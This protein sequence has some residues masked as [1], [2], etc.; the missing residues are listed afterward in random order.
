MLTPWIY[1]LPLQAQSSCKAVLAHGPVAAWETEQPQATTIHST[2]HALP[3]QKSKGFILGAPQPIVAAGQL[4][5]TPMQTCCIRL[6]LPAPL[7]PEL[8]PCLAA[9]CTTCFF[10][11]LNCWHK[12]LFGQP[13]GAARKR[14]ESTVV[15]VV[16]SATYAVP[17]QVCQ[18]LPLGVPH[19]LVAPSKLACA[20]HQSCGKACLHLISLL[21]LLLLLLLLRVCSGPAAACTFE[22]RNGA[23]RCRGLCCAAGHCCIL[24]LC[25]FYCYCWPCA[26]EAASFGACDGA[27]KCSCTLGC[28]GA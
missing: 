18:R 7:V 12:G 13:G 23:L 9:W 27:G 26:A 16:G 25:R 24:L 10:L 15:L 5:R 4:L 20:P 6:P 1:S 21:L 11:L 17:L 8:G 3:F 2:L 19:L 14:E 28:G 22:L